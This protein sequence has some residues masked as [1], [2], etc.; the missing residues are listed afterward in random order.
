LGLVGYASALDL[1]V[2]HT[3]E[4]QHL[5]GELGLR[6]VLA[7]SEMPPKEDTFDL[8]ARTFR[9]P[10]IQEYGGAEFGQV[11]IN[12]GKDRFDVFGDLNYV[13]ALPSEDGSVGACP[14]AITSL[15]RRYV[16]LIRYSVGDALVEP[17]FSDNHHVASFR[18][19]AGR[20]NDII[21]MP[22]GAYVHSV[23]IFHCIHQELAVHNI[24]MVLRD[25]GIEVRLAA[26][27]GTLPDHVLT[28]IRSRLLQ[29]HP[30]LP[31]CALTVV[32][33]VQTNRAG[34]RRWFIDERSNL[35]PDPRV[36]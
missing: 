33:D 25:T 34:K 30:A 15:Y 1:F 22:D 16:P 35:Q 26:S 27:Q 6:F 21:R 29:V 9:C 19:L 24:Q 28:A 11:A 8:L 14:I 32:P 3:T 17:C 23:A 5:F 20:I 18:R 10:V 36:H 31:L 13:D 12:F 7:T 4:F 2:R